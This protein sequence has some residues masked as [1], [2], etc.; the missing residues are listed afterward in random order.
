MGMTSSLSRWKKAVGEN[1]IQIPV[2][3]PCSMSR[4]L[5]SATVTS[6]WG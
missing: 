4:L 2:Q 1:Q 5:V 3:K 6:T